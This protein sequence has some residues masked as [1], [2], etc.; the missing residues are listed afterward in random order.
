MAHSGVPGSLQGVT[1]TSRLEGTVPRI[2]FFPKIV[3]ALCGG[4]SSSPFPPPE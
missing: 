1:G 4:L 3:E 2:I